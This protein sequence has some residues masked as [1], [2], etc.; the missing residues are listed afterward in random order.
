MINEA[1]KTRRLTLGLSENEISQKCGLSIDEYTDIESYPD[2]LETVTHI[3]EIRCLCKN[4]DFNIFSEL[5]I[6]Y[7]TDSN[8][9]TQANKNRHKLV[10]TKRKLL[11]LT[12]DELGNKIGFETPIIRKMESEPDFFETWS[13]ELI[14]E[15]AM[16]LDENIESFL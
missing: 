9:Y 5:G 16:Q 12:E 6:H 10:R 14:R 4:L 8:D 3:K 7:E 11:N 1:I 2:E 13:I 15:L